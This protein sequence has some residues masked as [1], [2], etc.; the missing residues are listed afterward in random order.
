MG[1]VKVI[2]LYSMAYSGTTWLNLILGS[3]KDILGIGA[4][5]R[6]FKDGPSKP[7][8][9]CLVHPGGECTFW[10]LFFKR[11]DPSDNFFIQLHRHTGISTFVANNP[12][13]ELFNEQFTDERLDV[14]VIEQV[15]NGQ[16]SLASAMRHHPERVTSV[17]QSAV[18]WLYRG[19]V[20]LKRRL[21][22]TGK[23]AMLLRYEDAVQ[24]PLGTL[25]RVAEYTGYPYTAASLRYWDFEHHLPGANQ[26]ALDILMRLQG[27]QGLKHGRKDYYDDLMQQLRKSDGVPKLDESW[28]EAYS[29]VDLAAY[30]FAAG[31]LYAEYGYPRPEV[32]EVAR[33]KFVE[34]YSPPPTPKE[35]LSQLPP[36]RHQENEAKGGGPE[37]AKSDMTSRVV[38]RIT[39][40]ISRRMQI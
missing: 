10:P 21:R 9:M 39:S 31:A 29:D 22:N 8:T 7:E 1:R 12:S 2:L 32:N 34:T 33:Q 20:N 36:W 27:G 4:G 19:T 30:D 16:A 24:D 28:R 3:G 38:K 5:D 15:R 18:V 13:M 25:E 6:L 23:P 40:F 37:N 26:G 14:R 35:A 11:Y 17:Y